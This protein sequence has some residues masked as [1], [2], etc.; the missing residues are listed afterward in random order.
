VTGRLCVSVGIFYCL[1]HEQIIT[2]AAGFD[3]ALPNS[4]LSAGNIKLHDFVTADYDSN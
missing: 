1:E 3:Q 4:E 2:R